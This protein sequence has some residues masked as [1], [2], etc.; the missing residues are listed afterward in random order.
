VLLP[1]LGYDGGSLLV[2]GFGVENGEVIGELVVD[3]SE[4]LLSFV[5]TS[6]YVVAGS[7]VGGFGLRQSVDCICICPLSGNRLLC[8]I[9]IVGRR[10]QWY[11]GRSGDLGCPLR[12]TCG[13]L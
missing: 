9:V 1:G 6:L 4:V 5:S 7:A 3:G 11:C 8:G 2:R 12:K 10:S 13:C